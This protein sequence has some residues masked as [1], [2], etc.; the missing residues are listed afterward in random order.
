MPRGPAARVGAPTAH[1]PPISGAGSPNVRIGGKPAWR[2][3]GAA[4]VPALLAAKSAADAAIRAAELNTLANLGTPGLPA[5]KLAEEAVKAATAAAMAATVAAAAAAGGDIHICSVPL[6]PVPHGPGVVIDGSATV[7]IN[8]L[9]ACRQGDT[10]V[11][12]VGPPDSVALGDP[13]V[14]IGG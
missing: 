3:V 9:P 6:P 12:A 14:M 10:L 2:G 8:G 5:A 4:G 1:G 11:E 13:R 7:R